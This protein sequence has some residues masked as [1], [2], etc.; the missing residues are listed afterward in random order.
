MAWW[1]PLA[2]AVNAWWAVDAP[3]C[4]PAHQLRQAGACAPAGPGGYVADLVARGG[5]FRPAPLTLEP[6][7]PVA[8][9]T[10][11][12]YGKVITDLTPIYRHPA[13]A[14]A[15]LPP[16]RTIEKGFVYV[17]LLARTQVSG[18]TFYQVNP[19][20]FVAG[21]ILTEARPSR[22]Q[23]I[24]NPPPGVTVGWV[25]ANTQTSPAPGLPPN[26]E[27]PRVG[28]YQAFQ[29]LAVQRVGDWEWYL[30]GPDQWL[31]QRQVALV[32]GTPPPGA[33]ADV[34]A[35]DTYE[36]SLGVY[37][38]GQLVFATL[39]SSGS[40]LFPTR[41]GT[42]RIWA[43]IDYA[44]MTG[45]YLRDRRDFYYVDDVPWTLYYDGDRALHG[46]YWHDNFGARSSHGCVNLSPRDSRWLF[47]FAH[48]GD[49]VVVF[50]SQ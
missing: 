6:V 32:R 34:I 27:S 45:A 22:F 12:A 21:D 30:I 4:A 19:G 42:F 13:D 10:P 23:G 8:G 47:N 25:I 2:L 29:L 5:P 18:T 46:A 1:L 3:L 17:S 48:V 26:P 40:R 33:P 31:E 50:S 38:G 20:E 11:H 7:P 43:K 39:I 14:L 28:R 49:T 35:V 41:P 24:H 16:V 37:R 9:L 36:Q 44:R 15:G